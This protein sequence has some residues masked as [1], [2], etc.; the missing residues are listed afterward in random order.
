MTHVLYDRGLWDT[1]II[2]S[3]QTVALALPEPDHTEFVDNRETEE[4]R[5][6]DIYLERE[7]YLAKV[8]ERDT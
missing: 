6:G 5:E 7:R 4:E 8:R 3:R 2:S 1:G